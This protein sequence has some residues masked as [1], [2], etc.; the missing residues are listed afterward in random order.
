MLP[1]FPVEGGCQCGAVR[2]RLTAPPLSVYNC[3][4]V[5]CRRGSGSTHEMSMPVRRDALRHLSGALAGFDKTAESG[6]VVRMQRCAV[7]GCKVWN[8]PLAF[9]ELA[10]VK[11]GTLDD[12]SWAVPVGNIW[13][14]HRLPWVAI[15]PRLVNFP[16]QPPDR[17][18]LYDA[19][20]AAT[21]R[22]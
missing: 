5:D 7:C 13:T 16:R 3:H 4:C 10:V 9:P 11:P 6:R 1:D 15:D 22:G 20:A 17:R 21:R 12:C 14:D 18:P 19:W 8:E 2:Y